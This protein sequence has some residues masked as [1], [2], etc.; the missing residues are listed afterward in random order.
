MP[1]LQFPIKLDVSKIGFK[2]A[3]TLDD[4]IRM[5]PGCFRKMSDCRFM[6]TFLYEHELPVFAG[7]QVRGKNSL[8]LGF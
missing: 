6:L 8:N 3:H 7:S 2:Y 4:S 5:L 1:Q